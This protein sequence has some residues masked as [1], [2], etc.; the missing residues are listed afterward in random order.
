MAVEIVQSFIPKGN[1]NRPG[2]SMVPRY[3]TI[4]TTANYNKGADALMHAKYVNSD[5]DTGVSWHFT[6]D[7]KRIVQHLPL[8]ENGWHAGD[9]Y[10]GVGNRQSIG[11]EICEN[12]DGDFEKAVDNA[13][14]LVAKLMREHNIAIE[15][16]V[17]HQ[18]WSGKNC[19]R[20]LLPRWNELIRRI[21][22]AAHGPFTDIS[23]DH[24]F[25]NELRA[26]KD[27]GYVKGRS[28]GSL[29]LSEEAIRVLV[30]VWRMFNDLKS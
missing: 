8:N 15:N 28:D 10:N 20:P 13:V 26:M 24:P 16:V 2:L 25:V 23:A 11:I 21:K 30:I 14:W 19:P 22:D 5:P 9:G 18:R 17:P 12:V 6:V 4:H 7:D 1:A 29:G 27:A 3:I